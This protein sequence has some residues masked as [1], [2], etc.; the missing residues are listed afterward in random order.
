MALYYMSGLEIG[1]SS[2]RQAKKEARKERREARKEARQERRED[3]KE[4]KAM[5]PKKVA[6]I[7]VAPAR[8]AFLTL[9]SLNAFGLANKLN[10]L[11]KTN[12]TKFNSF[13]SKF[14]GNPNDLRKTVSKGITKKAFF[15]GQDDII[16]SAGAVAGAI[17]AAT[18][19][20]IA[21]KKV[22]DETG[23]SKKLGEKAGEL[24]KAINLGKKQLSESPNFEKENMQMPTGEDVAKVE[25]EEPQEEEDTKKPNKLLLPLGLAAAFLFS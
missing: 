14:G 19:I 24:T 8:G 23:I 20:I 22:L 16:G 18:P 25:K 15:S 5:K 21:V 3:R 11:D 17:A 12:A 1:K 6:K 10:E 2:R 7:A 4:N 9:V 13:W